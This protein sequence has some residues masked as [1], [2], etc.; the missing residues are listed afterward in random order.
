VVDVAQ[1]RAAAPYHASHPTL[2][3]WSSCLRMKAA[4]CTG[5]GRGNQGILGPLRGPLPS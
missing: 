2:F 4:G 5:E 3:P 1:L